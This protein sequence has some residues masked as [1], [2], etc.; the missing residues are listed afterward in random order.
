MLSIILQLV[1]SVYVIIRVTAAALSGTVGAQGKA[2]KF[3]FWY[4]WS[5]SEVSA[6]AWRKMRKEGYKHCSS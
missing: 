3:D 6:A 5:N 1:G 4:Q 2:G